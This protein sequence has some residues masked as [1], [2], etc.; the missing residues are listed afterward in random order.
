MYS[1][2]RVLAETMGTLLEAPTD[3]MA[4]ELT[5]PPEKGGRFC[6][7]EECYNVGLDLSIDKDV[8]LGFTDIHLQ[9]QGRWEKSLYPSIY[10]FPESLW[11]I[12]SQITATAN[13]QVRVNSL[14]PLGS[15]LVSALQN[16]IHDLEDSI[17]GWTSQELVGPVGPDNMR[18]TTDPKHWNQRSARSLTQALHQSLILHFYRKI[19]N[20]STMI[21]QDTVG[22]ALEHLEICMESIDNP[23]LT[24]CIAWAAIV[25][26]R[27]ARN[28]NHKEKAT[29]I[30]EAIGKKGILL[31]DRAVK[32]AVRVA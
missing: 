27:E 16:H 4:G 13:E 20:V 24:I 25:A 3:D 7:A 18:S 26:A 11:T 5:D 6:L 15:T 10:G 22:R 23:D 17:W 28:A 8:D 29:T 9:V 14:Q 32:Q 30:L 2:L 31:G 19:Y 12:L 21:L 1:Y